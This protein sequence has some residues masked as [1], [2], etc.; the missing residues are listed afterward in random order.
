MSKVFLRVY[1]REIESMIENGLIEESI[2]HCQNI[3]KTFPMHVETYRL[4]GKSFLEGRR[5][6]DA[7]DIFQRVLMAVP[8]DFVAHVGMSIIRDDEG[9]LDDAI[10]H[11][12]RAFEDQ[13][14]NPA[15]QSELRR[16][17]GRRDGVEPHKIRLSRDALA[18]M[19]SQ[20]ELFNQAIAEIRAVL[21]EDGNRPDLQVM[22]ARAYYKAGQKVEA[23]EMAAILLKKYPY[24]LDALRILV[25]VLPETKTNENTQVYRQRL[26]MLDP[27]SS[28][29]A[30][31]TFKTDQVPESAVNME[32]LEYIEGASPNLSQ[33]NWTSSLGI[34]H[35]DEKR[36]EPAPDWIRTAVWQNQDSKEPEGQG[37]SGSTQP[38][39]SLAQAEIPDWLKSMAPRELTEAGSAPKEIDQTKTR[40]QD[41]D[42]APDWLNDLAAST[43]PETIPGS[44]QPASTLQDDGGFPDWLKEMGMNASAGTVAAFDADRL[45]QQQAEK[46]A[47]SAQHESS[48][49]SEQIP[50]A[51]PAGEELSDEDKPLRQTS[52]SSPLRSEDDAMSW[53]EDL[54]NEQGSKEGKPWSIPVNHSEDLPDWLHSAGDQPPVSTDDESPFSPSVIFPLEPIPSLSEEVDVN[55]TEPPEALSPLVSSEAG[56][57][58][59]LTVD[60]ETISWLDSLATEET[61]KTEEFQNESE[62][63]EEGL[64]DWINPAN[65]PSSIS[66]QLQTPSVLNETLPLEPISSQLDEM[67]V[68]F[69]GAEEEQTQF[70]SFREEASQPLRTED[71]ALGWLETLADKQR[72]REEKFPAKTEGDSD[73]L[74]DWL[75]LTDEP[76]S[77]LGA[78]ELHP[79]SADNL[80]LE[81]F[82]TSPDETVD[83]KTK[84]SEELQS[85][86]SPSEESHLPQESED[87]AGAW[88]ESLADKQEL[89]ENEN[90]TNPNFQSEELPDWLSPANEQPFSASGQVERPL[91]PET[92]P[93][94]GLP[95][96][97]SGLP[98]DSHEPS[99]IFPPITSPVGRPVQPINM[100]EFS[101][102]TYSNLGEM[103]NNAGDAKISGSD[104]DEN[105]LQEP[106]IKKDE[107]LS[108]ETPQD[109]ITITSWLRK[110][111]VQ[112]TL[113]KIQSNSEGSQP[114][115]APANELPDWLEELRKTTLSDEEPK[116]AEELPE[117]LRQT[118]EPDIH[119]E[120]SSP[121]A[122]P[123]LQGGIPNWLDETNPISEP[124][125]PTTPGEWVP[126]DEPLVSI[127]DHEPVIEKATPVIETPVQL[128]V[129]GG[130]GML[131]RIPTQDK[132]AEILS[133]AQVALDANQ[134]TEAMQAYTKLIK[135]N[136]LLEEV[137]HDLREAIYRYPVDIL[138]WQTLGDACMRANR[139]Q[140]ALDAYTKAEEL[141]R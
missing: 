67:T 59:P 32:R 92:L 88:L 103:Q 68:K 117:W 49:I 63:Q 100:D 75:N 79:A 11:M 77:T 110:Q 26:F 107:T 126:V 112:D 47:A 56:R 96:I 62:G 40:A 136:R 34:K 81:P 58:Q 132:D 124:P 138:V 85:N 24:C 72:V 123:S 108:P 3:L 41:E 10:W 127:P 50:F 28:F 141:L 104:R 82:P 27:Y 80:P 55:K 76:P 114:A 73:E 97:Q 42:E 48:L 113:G 8:D 14:S 139:L 109:D 131:A 22:L 31:S 122:V 19:Y 95:P 120:A 12:E 102:E 119:E 13:P 38:S 69:N 130:T 21:A 129:L 106:P 51:Q 1:N 37:D 45:E 35:L 5:Y 115:D 61:I 137:I 135:K 23:A 84:P 65:E 2:A 64:P 71:D 134:L 43:N 15:I 78:Q 7:A 46:L 89:K 4:L 86:L 17:Y 74:P 6:T 99:E 133:A 29:V 125:A 53:L 91:P 111:D 52:E 101:D 105:S 118:A 98:S 128:R 87:E 9:K 57:D 66:S 70:E 121:T 60:D 39:E 36:V 16:L 25:D 140:D 44:S 20:G 90:L 93:L 116:P 54:T 18:N 33:L 83:Q 94:V 30:G